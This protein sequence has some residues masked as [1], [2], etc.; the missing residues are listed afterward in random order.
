MTGAKQARHHIKRDLHW[1]VWVYS[2]FE[3]NNK[4]NDDNLGSKLLAYGSNLV[5]LNHKT[6]A[7]T[8]LT[9][10]PIFHL[11]ATDTAYTSTIRPY[12]IQ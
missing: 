2:L 4:H 5:F 10:N 3:S 9:Y 8:L 6:Q 11:Q 12:L 1:N 7:Q